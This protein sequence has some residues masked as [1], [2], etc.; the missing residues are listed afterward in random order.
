MPPG[1]K[2]HAPVNDRD[3]ALSYSQTRVQQKENQTI[4]NEQIG[5]IGDM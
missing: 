4:L 5:I 3:E 1:C 2:L